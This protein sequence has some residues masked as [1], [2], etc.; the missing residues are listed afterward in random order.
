LC[1][2]PFEAVNYAFTFPQV[3]RSYVEENAG[4]CVFNRNRN[5]EIFPVKAAYDNAC[6]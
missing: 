3:C 6:V 4:F 2:L 5:K 1:I